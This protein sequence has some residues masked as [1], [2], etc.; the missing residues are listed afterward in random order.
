MKVGRVDGGP[1]LVVRFLAELRVDAA[2]DIGPFSDAELLT[3]GFDFR[4]VL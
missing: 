1:D 3:V 2:G 4:G